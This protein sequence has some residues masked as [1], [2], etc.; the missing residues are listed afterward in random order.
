M[1]KN[2]LDQNG[3]TY[4]LDVFERDMNERIKVSEKRGK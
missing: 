1:A 2:A 4:D 3:L